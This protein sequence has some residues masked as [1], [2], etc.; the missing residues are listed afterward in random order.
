MTRV[1]GRDK[2]LDSLQVACRARRVRLEEFDADAVVLLPAEPRVGPAGVRVRLEDHLV[3]VPQLQPRSNRRV[4][5]GRV[6]RKSNFRRRCAEEGRHRRARGFDPL[7]ARL[8]NGLQFHRCAVEDVQH[9]VR[10][11]PQAARVEVGALARERVGGAH[12]RPEVRVVRRRER[13]KS[14]PLNL[15]RTSEAQPE[16][17]LARGLQKVASSVHG[18]WLNGDKRMATGEERGKSR[19]SST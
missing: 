4:A 19:A 7:V 12:V 15:T 17:G 9:G 11:R 6:A 14:L 16:R 5:L 1:R 18:G 13:P 3:A 2:L 8:Y 10:G